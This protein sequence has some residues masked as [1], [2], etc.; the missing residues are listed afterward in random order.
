MNIT[1]GALA[2]LLVG[3]V[4]YF[5]S[6]KTP[7]ENGEWSSALQWS[8]I[9]LV[10]GS[11]ILISPLMSFS[12]S[13]LIFVI[14]SGIAWTV[15]KCRLKKDASY[16]E[17]G[18]FTDYVGGFF[19]VICIL[20]LLRSFVAEPFQIPS[21]SMR[22]GLIKGDF[23]LVDKF[24][25]GLRLPVLNNVIIPTG[26]VGR[27]DV[28]VFAYPVQPEMNYIKRIVGVPGDIVEYRNKVLT[29]NGQA[30]ADTAAGSYS[31]TDDTDTSITHSLDV[32]ST[33]LGNKTFNVLKEEGQP[34]VSL[35]ALAQYT[36]VV[37][38]EHGYSVEQSG[39][40]NCQYAEDGSGFICKVPEGRYFAMGDNRDN[41]ADSRYWGFIDDKLVVGKA[42][43][44]VLNFREL[45]RIGTVIR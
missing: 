31:Y 1:I 25:Y 36:E 23:I 37:M 12:A 9:L 5:K 34:A 32:Y 26:T 11:F 33:Q 8:Y 41:S 43:L 42:F 15:H 35:P 18:H 14:I 7:Q 4:L 44:V 27:G 38:P 13:L 20:F 3:I 40:A 30:V 17:K 29:V 16:A 21:S 22:P 19:P 24:S 6:D 10:V 45:S 39:L 28:V 2:I